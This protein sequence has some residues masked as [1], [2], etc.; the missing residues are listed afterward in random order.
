MSAVEKGKVA[1]NSEHL[2]CL[3]KALEVGTVDLVV[4]NDFARDL[5]PASNRTRVKIHRTNV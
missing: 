1:L 3:I 2:E 4:G 5:Q